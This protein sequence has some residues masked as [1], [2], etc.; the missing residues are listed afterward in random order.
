MEHSDIDEKIKDELEYLGKFSKI[1]QIMKNS[2]VGISTALK[3]WIKTS[4]NL[5]DHKKYKKHEKR[6]VH[7]KNKLPVLV[8]E[9]EE[10]AIQGNFKVGGRKSKRIDRVRYQVNNTIL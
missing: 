8:S 2:S 4:Y 9:A 10:L 5:I 1:G 3:K 7:Y 6:Y